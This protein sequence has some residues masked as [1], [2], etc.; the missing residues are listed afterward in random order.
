VSSRVL[1]HTLHTWR[2]PVRPKHVVTV[3]RRLQE[4]INQRCKVER[5]VG[6]VARSGWCV[7]SET[8]VQDVFVSAGVAEKCIWSTF[9]ISLLS[10]SSCSEF[11]FR[12][13]AAGQCLSAIISP[14][15][16]DTF[17]GYTD[18]ISSAKQNSNPPIKIDIL[19]V[20]SI[21]GYARTNQK[22]LRHQR[23]R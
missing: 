20:I 3:K 11:L 1:H 14:V 15:H 23:F 5:K 16:N 10:R 7:A 18:D 12:T 2:W 9:W 8:G 22:F 13:N 19:I 6:Y 17:V 4:N 21:C